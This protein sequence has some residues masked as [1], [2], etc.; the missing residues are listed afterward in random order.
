MKTPQWARV[1]I[2]GVDVERYKHLGIY[3]NIKLD[4]S[5]NTGAKVT[6]K[7]SADWG[8]LESS[9]W[10]CGGPYPLHASDSNI[11]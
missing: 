4:W 2:Q 5:N 6:C 7:T 9:A 11:S 10:D 8:P 1:N 3:L